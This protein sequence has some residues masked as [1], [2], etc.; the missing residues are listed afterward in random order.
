MFTQQSE[1][2]HS[3]YTLKVEEEVINGIGDIVVAATAGSGK[4]TLIEYL[5]RNV[6]KTSCTVIAFNTHI[7]SAM[8]QRLQ[9]LNHVNVATLHAVGNGCVT[10][11]LGRTQRPDT[12]KYRKI[13]NTLIDNH[14]V[15][16]SDKS[17][18]LPAALDY[19]SKLDSRDEIDEAKKQILHIGEFCRLTLTNYKSEDNVQEMI[20]QYNL[21]LT[22]PFS[23]VFPII[24]KIIDRGIEKA[25]E[26]KLIDFTDMIFLPH[27]WN[28]KPYQSSWVLVDEGQDLNKAQLEIAIKC[29]ANGGR[30][31]F[32]GDRDQA[33]M[34]FAGADSSSID[35]IIAR[36][37]AQ[38]LPLSICYRC[39]KSHIELARKI[40]DNIEPAEWAIDGTID[41]IKE[42][43]LRSIVQ[44][45]DLIIGRKTAPLIKQCISLIAAGIKA[46][47]RGREIGKQLVAITNDV[48]KQ[49]YFTFANFL[50]YLE[51]Y[52]DSK[53]AKF[54]QV[55]NDAQ[56]EATTDKCMA[57]EAC[58][59]NINA[60]DLND[61]CFN[62]EAMF[63]NDNEQPPVML[64][65]V[66]RAKG[67]ENDRVFILHPE[68]LPLRWNGQKPDQTKQEHNLKFVSLTRAK[69]S[70]V[71]VAKPKKTTE[72]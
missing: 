45:G 30:M 8:R 7:V 9:G 55:Q 63:S 28:L 36:T 31:I 65:T 22:F 10:S 1:F 68:D 49:P 56:I 13:V 42:D 26:E 18:F 52:K 32:V 64:S 70:L 25:K 66:H 5:V 16:F 44:Y 72:E 69:Q 57:V 71:F 53:I 27:V 6:I 33:I 15:I 4:S 20:E 29:R 34:G 21:D 46:K 61:L 35:N 39:P 11:F 47:V 37:N 24:G 67:L 50:V 60:R 19:I 48:A 54:K 23:V 3:K 14:T 43:K 38:E 62:M 51:A 59:L 40:T 58:Y 17:T 2:K 41:Y 12:M